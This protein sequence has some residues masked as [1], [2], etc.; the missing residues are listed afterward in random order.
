MLTVSKERYLL[1][2]SS[3]LRDRQA[4]RGSTMSELSMAGPEFQR[5]PLRLSFSNL[6]MC[7]RAD[8]N[9]GEDLYPWNCKRQ[10]HMS[11]INPPAY[12]ALI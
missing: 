4:E 3:D 8:S 1:D 6:V 5:S 12:K 9:C 7:R 2:R 11:S 10:S